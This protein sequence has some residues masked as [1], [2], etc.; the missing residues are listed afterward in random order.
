MP[1]G[2]SAVVS[3]PVTLY[4]MFARN[5]VTFYLLG[6]YAFKTHHAFTLKRRNIWKGGNGASTHY[7][8]TKS[9]FMEEI[10]QGFWK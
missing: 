4:Y 2:V 3:S 1:F 9:I 6:D 7:Y 8:N 5:T 10:A